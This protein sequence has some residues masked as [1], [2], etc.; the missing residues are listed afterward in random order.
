[1]RF[2]LWLTW[3]YL[4][5]LLAWGL[6]EFVGERTVPTLLLAYVPPALLAWPAPLLLLAALVIWAIRKNAR[7]LLP[8]VLACLTGLFYLG[9]TWHPA[10]AA[11]PGDITL[12]TFNVARGMLGSVE[13]L[14]AQVRA[15]QPDVITMQETNGVS[16][17]FARR[18]AVALPGYQL[19]Q[20]DVIGGEVLTF[21]RYP[22]L[23][24]RTIMLPG[25][26]RRFLVTRVSTPQ[27]ELTLINVHFSTV[28]VSGVRQGQV[29]PTRDVRAEQLAILLREVNAIKGPL[30]VVGD[31]NTP[32]RG[33]MYAALK[34]HFADAWDSAGRGLGY[35]FQSWRPVLRIDH[36]F[37]R[38]LR[39]INA[40]VQPHSGSDHRALVARLRWATGP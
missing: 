13:R 39:P 11:Q 17:S 14:S 29:I 6:G 7:A 9:F 1:M 15:A 37:A 12:L 33:R 22:V 3:T 21:S 30:I 34:T 26:Y 32:P 16:P 31:F 19:S 20:S 27:G 2:L 40:E 8:A 35:T 24:T 4:T 28:K 23:S 36:V 18:M 25:T 5:L 38:G 10:Q